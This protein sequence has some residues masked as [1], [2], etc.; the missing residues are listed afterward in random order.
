MSLGIVVLNYNDSKTTINFINNIKQ[1]KNIS[2]IVIVDNNSTDNSLREIRKYID[3]NIILIESK[4]NNG[5]GAGNNLGINFIIENYDF[6]YICISN[7]DIEIEENSIDKIVDFLNC[8]QD[9]SLASGRIIE[10]NNFAEDGSWKLPTYSQ[11]LFQCIPIIDKLINKSLSYPESFFK[12]EYSNVDIVKGCFFIARA[13]TLKEINSFDEDTF[14]Y[15]EENILGKK[16]KSKGFKVAVLNN[17]NIIH[18]HGVTIN[19]ALKKIDKFKVLGTSREVYIKKYLN[20]SYL[21][22]SIYKLFNSF[23][24]FLRK[25]LYSIYNIIKK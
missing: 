16:L 20:N 17:V 2:K 4:E 25:C 11:C 14:L 9:I 1:F 12:R 18:A 10:N 8:H 3:N 22:L 24:L 23:G 6:D 21:A 19:K 15:Y 5:Y 13:N 7:P